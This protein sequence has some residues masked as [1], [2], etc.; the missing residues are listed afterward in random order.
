[1]WREAALLNIFVYKQFKK[2]SQE[3]TKLDTFSM[4]LGL[5]ELDKKCKKVQPVPQAAMWYDIR[6]ASSKFLMIVDVCMAEM[7]RL[8]W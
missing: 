7:V 8:T 4:W 5:A 3:G 6:V 2:L 1:M